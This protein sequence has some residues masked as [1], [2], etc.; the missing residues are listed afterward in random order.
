MI[1]G[2]G[3]DI[4]HAEQLPDGV[5]VPEDSFARHTFT[6]GEQELAAKRPS[7]TAFLRGRFAAKEAVFKA[8]GMD[9]DALG[10]WDAIEVLADEHGAPFV[11]LHGSARE[12]AQRRGI[13][14]IQVSLSSDRDCF[15][16]F[17]V[18]ETE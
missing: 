10:R 5:L 6:S 7:P 15:L 2:I 1:A 9:S 4:V 12:A 11:Q 8:L 3:V 18:A 16:A 13:A 17:C 14:H